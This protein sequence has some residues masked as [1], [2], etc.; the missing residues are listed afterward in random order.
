MRVNRLGDRVNALL[1]YPECPDTFWSFRHALRL[2]HKEA[3]QPPLGLLTVAAMLP[4][5][6]KLLLI[7]LNVSELSEADLAWA[8]C[9]LVSGMIVQ[10]ASARRVI[11]RCKEAGVTVVAGGPL[12]TCE[13]EGFEDVDHFVLDEAEVT[14]PLFLEDYES[15]VAPRVAD[16]P[17]GS[18]ATPPLRLRRSPVL[19]RLPPQLRVLQRHAAL[20]TS[21]ADEDGCPGRS[22]T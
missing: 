20:R 11:S 19:P 6:W 9:A 1:L 7:D 3:A 17:V 21:L 12:F 18:G 13:H 22:R 4:D 5:N 2:A 16:T 8:D 15:G 10:R 14:L